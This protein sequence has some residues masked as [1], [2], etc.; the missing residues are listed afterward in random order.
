MDIVESG[1]AEGFQRRK[2]VLLVG[3]NQFHGISHLSQERGARV[4]VRGHKGYIGSVM[5]PMLQA[6]GYEVVGLEN[7]HAR[8]MDF[9]NSRI[10]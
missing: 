2:I 1:K 3:D 4:L 8:F 5:V 6:A 9:S 7:E 10:D